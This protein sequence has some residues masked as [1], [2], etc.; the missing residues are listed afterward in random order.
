MSAADI[1]WPHAPPH[2]LGQAGTYFVTGSTY[3]KAHHFRGRDR[4]AVLHRG[5]LKMAESYGWQLEPW[6]AFSNHYHFV[7]HSPPSSA[8]TLRPMLS[9]LHELTAKWVNK[10]DITPGRK[11]W[12]NFR[13]TRL[14]IQP[15]YL[16]RLKYVHHNAVHHGLVPIANQYRFCSAGWFERSA[17]P[18]QIKTIYGLKV[19]KLNVPD[20]F[21]PEPCLD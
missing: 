1:P 21:A 4:L 14:T 11:V 16:A 10:L 19:D 2:R 8:E 9:L 13:D 6:A 5:L 20:D 17:T 18:A 15:S 12:H 7:A 3:Q